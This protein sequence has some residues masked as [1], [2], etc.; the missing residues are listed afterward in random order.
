MLSSTLA[1][2]DFCFRILLSE[3]GNKKPPFQP[4]DLVPAMLLLILLLLLEIE[5]ISSL[6]VTSVSLGAASCSMKSLSNTSNLSSSS[7][8][9]EKSRSEALVP[10]AML[11]SR[12]NLLSSYET[13]QVKV[14]RI[15]S[16]TC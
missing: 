15:A 7:S 12:M 2:T 3:D 13:I 4:E 9:V 10:E 6:F 11:N 1:F 16:K 8:R 5:D 14:T